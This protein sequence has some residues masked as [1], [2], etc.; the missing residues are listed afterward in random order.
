MSIDVVAVPR[1]RAGHATSGPGERVASP[2]HY[3]MCPPTFFDVSYAINPWMHP[4]TPVDHRLAAAQWQT[5]RATFEGLGHRVELIDPVEGLPDM[6]FAANGG[7]VVDG[8]A[9]SSRFR[10]PQRTG[11]ERPYHQWLGE[12]G[13]RVVTRP[14]RHLEGEG[15]VLTVAGH[16]LVGSG[17]RSHPQAASLVAERLAL[18][19]GRR[20][21]ALELVDPRYYHLDT[22][23]GIL[24]DHTAVYLPT[25]FAPR[26]RALLADVFPELVAASPDDAA[27]LGVNVVSDG[28][29]V[30]LERAATGLAAELERRGFTPIGVDMSEF[31]KSGGA[32][33]CATLELRGLS[34]TVA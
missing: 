2:R 26:S 21:V 15:D 4:D 12:H 30:V 31:R 25:A 1:A 20:V 7:V 29:H 22:A 16:L 23:L 14:V 13:A 33:K 8:Y 27:V 32:V 34:P 10:Y 3:L 19:T 18:P 11:E 24:D 5:L 9:L 28:R 17:F 6:V